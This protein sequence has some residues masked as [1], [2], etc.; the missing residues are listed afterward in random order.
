MLVVGLR[1]FQLLVLALTMA[2]WWE[3]QKLLITAICF[4]PPWGSLLVDEGSFGLA[5][6]RYEIRDEVLELHWLELGKTPSPTCQ[7]KRLGYY[8]RAHAGFIP[9]VYS[10]V[11]SPGSFRPIGVLPCSAL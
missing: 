4:A 2:A 1:G 8:A 9:Y 6:R 3:V 7:G 10:Y 11:A 5:L